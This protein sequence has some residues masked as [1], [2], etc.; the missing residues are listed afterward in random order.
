MLLRQGT[1]TSSDGTSIAFVE[2][3]EPSRPPIIFIHGYLFST[4]A[5]ERQIES[6]LGSSFRLV[7]L[8]LRGH[9]NSG[10]PE[11][12]SAYQDASLWAD[13][14]E[15]VLNELDIERALLVGWS[16]GS[17]VALNYAWCKG[18]E[19]IAGMN[20]VAATLATTA[21]DASGGLT[22]DLRNLLSL[23]KPERED[24]TRYFLKLCGAPT[25]DLAAEEHFLDM[26]MRVPPTARLGARSWM[27]PYDDTLSWVTVPTMI[28]HGES[29][30]V[31]AE[32]LSRSH[33]AAIPGARLDITPDAGHLAF[34]QN[35]EVFNQRL[36][37]FAREVF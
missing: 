14:V 29:D 19:R 8:D 6:S 20:L 24:A 21:H 32:A 28:T 31:V 27:L 10:K 9:G 4:D 12:S 37:S 11:A 30:P 16:L 2:T 5:F 7:A 33:V 1:T 15:V 25:L 35:P 36:R 22:Q 26:A 13:D 23:S 3:G 18:F 17:R 34:F